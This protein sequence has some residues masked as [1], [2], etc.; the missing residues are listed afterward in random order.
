MNIG[1]DS[2]EIITK[3]NITKKDLIDKYFEKFN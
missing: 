1:K 2:K 3:N